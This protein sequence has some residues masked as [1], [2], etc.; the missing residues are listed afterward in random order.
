MVFSAPKLSRP[1][2]Y[3]AKRA[4]RTREQPRKAALSM[5]TVRKMRGKQ[6]AV[7]METHF[8]VHGDKRCTVAFV[9]Y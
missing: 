8:R 5:V 3:E 2:I 1:A 4:G 6:I 9:H 7:F